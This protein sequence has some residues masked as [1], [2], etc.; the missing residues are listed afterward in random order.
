MTQCISQLSLGFH[1]ELPVVIEFDAPEISSDGGALLLRQVDDS[2]GL[3]AGFADCLNDDRDPLRCLHSRHEQTRQRVFQI[4][5]GYED[6]NDADRLRHDPLLKTVCDRA[7]LTGEGLSSQPTLSRFEGSQ[8][9][10]TLRRLVRHLEDS[11]VAELPADTQ[12]I[13]LDLDATAD[14]THGAQQ[15]SFFSGFYDQ[16]IYHPL[17]VFDSGSGQLISAIL[18]PGKVHASRGAAGVLRRL[19]RKLKRRFPQAQIAVR[20]DSG[21]CTPALLATLEKL[22]DELGDVD[23]LLGLPKNPVL[24]RHAQ[25]TMTLAQDLYRR[26]GTK[27]Q[28]FASFFYAA[29]SWPRQRFVVVKA[30]HGVLGANPR[31]VLTSLTGFPPDILYH[32]YCERGQC[33]N[34]IKDLKNALQADRLSCSAFQANF[35]RLLL[36]ALAYRLLHALRKRVAEHS[37]EL[38]RAQFDTLRLRLLKVAAWVS[39]SVR[40]ILV[41]LPKA[42]PYAGLFRNLCLPWQ[43]PPIPA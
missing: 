41:R 2:L 40:R 26:R 29:K 13:V 37:G 10:I 27:A 42:F 12:L 34:L 43:A 3:T 38:G 25:I 4:A 11:Y 15:L 21:F 7:A 30:E 28:V 14:E 1:P 16:F 23:Y 6:C 33:E 36:H 35:F 5:L 39:Q 20:A 24:L 32:A 8:K 19:I 22:N 31:F 18:R 17:L 9:G